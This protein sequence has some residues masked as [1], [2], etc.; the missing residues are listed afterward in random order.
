MGHIGRE[1]TGCKCLNNKKIL[2]YEQNGNKYLRSKITEVLEENT[3]FL[4]YLRSQTTFV[5]KNIVGWEENYITCEMFKIQEDSCPGR[6][7]E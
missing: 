6:E 7:L 1:Y 5:L 3:V 4:Q 2:V